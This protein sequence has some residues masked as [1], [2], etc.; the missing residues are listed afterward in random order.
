MYLNVCCTSLYG[1]FS[2]SDSN[3]ADLN[4]PSLHPSCSEGWGKDISVCSDRNV[5]LF[6]IGV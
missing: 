1:L 4:I 6:L 5:S 3:K 2:S